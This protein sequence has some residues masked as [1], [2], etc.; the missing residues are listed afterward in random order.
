MIKGDKSM[1][2][3]N[4]LKSGNCF[5]VLNTALCILFI[6]FPAIIAPSNCLAGEKLQP[7]QIWSELLKR[8]T[9]PYTV[10]LALHKRTPVDG[11]YT[12]TIPMKEAHV[13]CKR[14]PDWLPEGGV[15][16]IN[17]TKGTFRIIHEDTSWRTIGSFFIAGDRMVLAN[18][19]VC[20]D[21]IGMY[22]WKLEGDKL[23][24][25][26]IDDGCAI[27][28]RAA[29]LTLGPWF[30]CRPPNHEAAITE[31]WPKPDGCD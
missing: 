9:Y 3:L 30:S 31:H 15:W 5:F 2:N 10:P 24:L 17:F 27:R 21:M 8:S 14:C 26:L 22:Q 11:T 28:L 4:A 16:K 18:D 13:P 29:N 25:R 12:R 23:T 19:P 6:Y 7:K 1:Y 20:H